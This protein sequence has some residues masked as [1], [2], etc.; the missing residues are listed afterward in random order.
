MIFAPGLEPNLQTLTSNLYSKGTLK[1]TVNTP[2]ATADTKGN[3]RCFII[4]VAVFFIAEQGA[5]FKTQIGFW[6]N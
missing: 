1:I 2:E 6:V 4:K 5:K 3:G